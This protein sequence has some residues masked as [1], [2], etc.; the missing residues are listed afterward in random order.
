MEDRQGT[1]TPLI[2]PLGHS[3]YPTHIKEDDIVNFPLKTDDRGVDIS[4]SKDNTYSSPY[5]M[6]Y[7]YPNLAAEHSTSYLRR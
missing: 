1:N 5:T 7:R 6:N 4:I 3:K 2:F